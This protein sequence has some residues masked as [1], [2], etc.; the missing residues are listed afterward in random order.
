M[1]VIALLIAVFVP[2]CG[3]FVYWKLTYWQR[4]GI[5]NEI[6]SIFNRFVE[7]FHL[8]DQNSQRKY[9]DVVGIYEGLRPS[10]MVTD[11][12]MVKKVLIEEF[13]NFPN[14]RVS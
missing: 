8:A 2:L 12:V 1:I 7:P 4:Q 14:H 5:P 11:P 10:L 3:F 6:G 13:H 9:G